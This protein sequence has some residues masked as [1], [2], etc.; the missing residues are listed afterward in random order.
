MG[1]ATV[2]EQW[3]RDPN[4]YNSLASGCP[5]GSEVRWEGRSTVATGSR[6][7][8]RSSHIGSLVR[9]LVSYLGLCA[10]RRGR[11]QR[12]KM[13]D[14]LTDS[15]NENAPWG[16]DVDAS[17]GSVQSN[18][19]SRME[20]WKLRQYTSLYSKQ[21]RKGYNLRSACLIHFPGGHGIAYNLRSRTD[22]T[23]M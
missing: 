15:G 9:V 7:I 6:A 17:R 4:R 21:I 1:Q 19:A 13:C 8:H 16:K 14:D 20:R 3:E 18:D 22:Q 5:S 11:F 2:E 10:Y 23:R 12:R